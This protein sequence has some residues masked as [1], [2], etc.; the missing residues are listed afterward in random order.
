MF[1]SVYTLMQWDEGE[2]DKRSRESTHL[3]TDRN[4]ESLFYVL[5]RGEQE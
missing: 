5:D 4:M 3:D 2:E 1:D